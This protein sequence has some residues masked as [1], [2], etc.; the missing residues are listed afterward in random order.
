MALSPAHKFGQLIGNL[1]EEVL[2]PILQT[3]C[4]RRQLYLDKKGARP[5]V[6]KGR[7][8]TWKDKYGN[9]HDLDFVIE[10]EST[11]AQRGRPVAFIECAWR[12]YTKHSRNKAQEI[13]GAL[14]P[15]RDDNCHDAPFLGAVIAGEFTNPSIEQLQSV[16][17]EVLYIPYYTVVE[18]F[19]TGGID[20]RFDE[21]TSD[22]T[23]SVCVDAIE[24][25]RTTERHV[26][27]QIKEK[28]VELNENR[29]TKFTGSLTK[30]LDRQIQIVLILPLY[31]N[32]RR[33][34]E[35]DKAID[36]LAGYSQQEP[37]RNFQLYEV[38]VR[39]TNGDNINGQFE[40]KQRA[41]DFL[42]MAR[43]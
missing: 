21:E 14:L 36:F 17:F 20:T 40:E 4:D 18:A 27:K 37:E 30:T 11:A 5:G 2:E 34:S 15:I 32:Q 7:K 31:G 10:K 26:W 3:Y 8:L 1:M 23:F 22:S 41:I 9:E 24:K 43:V 25:V 13:Q 33:F 12:R 16:G 35:V 29:I 39:Y 38:I 42:N 6:R 19:S 28:L